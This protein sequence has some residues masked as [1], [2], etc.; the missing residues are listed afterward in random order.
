MAD[1]IPNKGW[2]SGDAGGWTFTQ[3]T[4]FSL[5]IGDSSTYPAGTLPRTGTYC[6]F[7]FRSLTGLRWGKVEYSS[8]DYEIARGKEAIFTVY[9]KWYAASVRYP[10]TKYIR[11]DDGVGQTDYNLDEGLG[12]G[13]QLQT[14]TRTIDASATKLD[15]IIYVEGLDTAHHRLGIDDMNV[16][17]AGSESPAT[18][19]PTDPLARVTGLVHIYDRLKGIYQL[20]AFVGDV[21]TAI[22]LLYEKKVTPATIKELAE[23]ARRMEE[24]EKF[25]EDFYKGFKG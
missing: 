11:I 17:V 9:R 15:F 16:T 8:A 3:S 22:A 24:L 4:G 12:D 1:W 7:M 19:Y 5:G 23:V 18:V 13:F 20:E 2:E 14:V 21:S 10:Q 6:L 25:A